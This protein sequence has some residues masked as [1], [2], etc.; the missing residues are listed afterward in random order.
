[1]DLLVTYTLPQ[2]NF[3]STSTPSGVSEDFPS[4]IHQSYTIIVWDLEKQV[5]KVVVDIYSI[6]VESICSQEKMKHQHETPRKI[7]IN[8]KIGKHV[9]RKSRLLE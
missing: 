9:L 6:K 8:T 2:Y 3:Y 7:S 1:M 4:D 5:V